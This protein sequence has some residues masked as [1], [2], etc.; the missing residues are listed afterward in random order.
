M[1]TTRDPDNGA[2]L[3]QKTFGSANLVLQTDEMGPVDVF[4]GSNSGFCLKVFF[5]SN[6]KIKDTIIPAT[7]NKIKYL[8]NGP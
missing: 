1:T 3:F 6:I 5:F 7:R 2:I 8:K 4:T